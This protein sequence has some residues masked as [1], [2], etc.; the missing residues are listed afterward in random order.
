M[1]FFTCFAPL[2]SISSPPPG[3]PLHCRF[4]PFSGI[5]TDELCRLS[6]PKDVDLI[7]L[8]SLLN[9]PVLCLSAAYRTLVAPLGPSP[10]SLRNSRLPISILDRPYLSFP[11]CLFSLTRSI[12]LVLFTSESIN[13]RCAR[14][15]SQKN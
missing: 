6:R 4:L 14:L 13:P 9:T 5:Y 15:F 2:C 7:A 10:F 3:I 11:T 12:P 8:W 1:F